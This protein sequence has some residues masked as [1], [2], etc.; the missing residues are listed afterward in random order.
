MERGAVSSVSGHEG[1]SSIDHG[2]FSAELERWD[3]GGTALHRSSQDA[4]ETGSELRAFF[5]SDRPQHKNSGAI[6]EE[7]SPLL[8][9]LNLVSTSFQAFTEC[10]R[11]WALCDL[12]R[13]IY[14]CFIDL[15]MFVT[16]M[17]MH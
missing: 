6:S 12:T 16:L 17:I 14:L 3:H 5:T 9:N 11:C 2:S 8:V 15:S 7:V 4:S 1:S 13:L 10:Q